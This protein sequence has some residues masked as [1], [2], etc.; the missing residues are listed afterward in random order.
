MN[1]KNE[2]IEKIHTF[3]ESLSDWGWQQVYFKDNLTR[4]CY[5]AEGTRFSPEYQSEIP[6]SQVLYLGLLNKE[7]PMELNREM[8]QKLISYLNNWMNGRLFG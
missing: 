6:G 7:C 5:M 1:E 3:T 4:P 8:A 2:K